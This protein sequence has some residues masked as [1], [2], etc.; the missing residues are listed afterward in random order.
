[1]AQLISPTSC[2]LHDDVIKWK[3]IPRYWPFVCRIHRSPVNSPHKGQWRGAL[4][5][6]MICA[7]ING[8]A[9]NREVGDLRRHRV[10]YDVTVM[11]QLI[12][13]VYNKNIRMTSH[14]WLIVLRS[15]G[16]DSF[17]AQIIPHNIYHLHILFYKYAVAHTLKSLEIQPFWS[18]DQSISG[19][20]GQYHGRWCPD[21]LNLLAINCHYIGYVI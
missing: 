11:R 4:M 3:H 18:R 19:K 2:S 10:H 9:N 5:F 14:Y 6:H 17:S 15:S 16:I 8:W 13:G 21:F 12:V 7:W 1:M 20:I